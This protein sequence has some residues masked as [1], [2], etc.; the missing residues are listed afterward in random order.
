MCSQLGSTTMAYLNQVVLGLSTYFFP[1]DALSEQK[2]EM[3]SIIRN[4]YRLKV[5][6]YTDHMIDINDYF[7]AF[8][9]ENPSDHIGDTSLN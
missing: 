1:V 8:P 6:L 9:C 5:I 2:K 3:C 4:P 7:N